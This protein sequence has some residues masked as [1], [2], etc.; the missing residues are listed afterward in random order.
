M[1][2]LVSVIADESS[3]AFLCCWFRPQW[4]TH[5]EW[6][7][8]LTALDTQST[9]RQGCKE[10]PCEQS[11]I[12]HKVDWWWKIYV[13]FWLESCGRYGIDEDMWPDLEIATWGQATTWCRLLRTLPTLFVRVISDCGRLLAGKM[14]SFVHRRRSLWPWVQSYEFFWKISMGIFL[15]LLH[16]RTF[17]ALFCQAV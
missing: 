12:V 16:Y 3:D 2:V 7:L 5:R 14:W 15:Q 4:I 1:A 8:R 17:P 11:G 10:Q 6:P 13:W 9:A